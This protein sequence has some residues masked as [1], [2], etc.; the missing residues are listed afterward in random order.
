MATAKSGNEKPSILD[1]VKENPL[2]SVLATVAFLAATVTATVSGVDAIDDLVM[3]RAEHDADMA[4][5]TA[6]VHPASEQSLEELKAW[7]RCDRLERR[8]TE[9]EDRLW[10]EEHDIDGPDEETV[11]QIKSDVEKAEREFDALDCGRT[12]AE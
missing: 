7:N 9:L 2:V 11:R 6:G 1:V 5:H 3:T 10:R 4:V 12:L 8:I